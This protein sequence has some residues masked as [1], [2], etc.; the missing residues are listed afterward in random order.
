MTIEGI[1]V[2]VPSDN[3]RHLLEENLP[4][5]LW[6]LEAAPFP[7]ELVVVDDGSSDGTPT[8]LAERYPEA[9]CLSLCVGVGAIEAKNTGPSPLP[10][11]V[12]PR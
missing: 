9:I 3:G 2:V 7:T 12:Y 6:A 11:G 4:S 1:T 10:F 5:L 8:Y